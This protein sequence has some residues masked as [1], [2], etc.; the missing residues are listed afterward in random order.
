ME[1]LCQLLC[2]LSQDSQVTE[3]SNVSCKR[4]AARDLRDKDTTLVQYYSLLVCGR[5]WQ[6]L[7]Q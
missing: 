6:T 2:H 4:P 1:A 3:R 7:A 5:H